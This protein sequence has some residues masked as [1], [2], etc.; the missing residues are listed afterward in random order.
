MKDLD[1]TLPSAVSVE[2]LIDLKASDSFA[3]ST[4]NKTVVKIT[5]LQT[6]VPVKSTLKLG[7]PD[8]TVLFNRLHLMS[9]DQTIQLIVPGGV[10]YLT[11]TYG[12][13]NQQVLIENGQAKFSFVP[14]E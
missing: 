4:E 2:N 12:S 9:E 10:S 3:W 5:G 6:T 1:D 13:I 11:L 7:L 8:G 14:G